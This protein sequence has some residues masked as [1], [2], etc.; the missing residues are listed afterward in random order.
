MLEEII[1]AILKYSKADS[2][3]ITST[4]GIIYF[5]MSTDK[6]RAMFMKLA[7]GI[8]KLLFSR[9]ISIS[10]K[11]T[12][13]G[14]LFNDI[15][16]TLQKAIN[17]N[18]KDVIEDIKSDVKD[19]KKGKVAVDLGSRPPM[20]VSIRRPIDVLILDK[21]YLSRRVYYRNI[22]RRRKLRRSL[23]K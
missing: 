21:K 14:S 7:N 19:I 8:L 22:A 4:L 11:F 9:I 16:T 23:N 15:L 10:L 5:I 18:D 13:K 17:D 3:K 20:F 6:T 2:L 1:E 12:K